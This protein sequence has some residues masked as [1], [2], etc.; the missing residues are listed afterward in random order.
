MSPSTNQQIQ[1]LKKQHSAQVKIIQ[2]QIDH[3]DSSVKIDQFSQILAQL[4][5]NYAKQEQS[6]IKGLYAEGCIF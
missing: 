6:L 4:E 1:D 3:C 5:F 2:T